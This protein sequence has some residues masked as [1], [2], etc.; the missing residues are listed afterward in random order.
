MKSVS[1][2]V[3]VRQRQRRRE[4]M[5]TGCVDGEYRNDVLTECVSRVK[6]SPFRS[7]GLFRHESSIAG[8]EWNIRSAA[9]NFP[10]A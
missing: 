1:R 8:S 10:V 3:A 7:A 6:G 9:S 2:F 5:T 4:C